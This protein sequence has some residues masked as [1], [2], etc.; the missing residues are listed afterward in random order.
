MRLD[1]SGPIPLRSVGSCRARG[2]HEPTLGDRR[3]AN[4]A[5]PVFFVHLDA[6]RAAAPPVVRE[7]VQGADVKPRPDAVGSRPRHGRTSSTKRAPPTVTV[8]I[9]PKNAASALSART[10]PP[11]I[12][13]RYFSVVSTDS[14]PSHSLMVTTSTP[15][16]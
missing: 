7:V 2:R 15:R 5:G 11:A 12:R 16:A 9:G 1:R 8:S 4:V 14:W 6:L 10:F 3:R 13:A